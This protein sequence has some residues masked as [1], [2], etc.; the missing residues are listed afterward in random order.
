VSNFITRNILHLPQPSAIERYTNNLIVFTLSGLMHIVA[1][2]GSLGFDS[3]TEFGTM[4]FFT[5]FVLGFMIEDGVQAIWGRVSGTRKDESATVPFW[6]KIVG[7][8]WV[9]AWMCL[10]SPWFIYPRS[11]QPQENNYFVPY[12]IVGRFGEPVAQIAAGVLGLVMRFAFK[13]EI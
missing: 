4:I 3:D 1:L 12:S 10:V 9:V 6:H 5:S 2:W 7:H 13:G 8:V 11:R